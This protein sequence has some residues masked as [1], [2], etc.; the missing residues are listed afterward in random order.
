MLA[1]V[2]SLVPPVVVAAVLL[3]WAS[4]DRQRDS[5]LGRYVARWTS[6]G[7]EAARLIG[8]AVSAVRAW[9]HAP[10]AIVCGAVVVFAVWLRG[11]DR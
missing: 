9:I 11:V 8:F 5:V 4:F 6:P 10:A 1:L 2:I 3:R 7:A